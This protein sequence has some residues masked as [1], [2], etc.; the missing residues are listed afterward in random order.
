M[1]Y[2]VLWS[3]LYKNKKL[4][5]PPYASGITFCCIYIYHFLRSTIQIE[6]I[7]HCN[8]KKQNY[9]GQ[10]HA[11]MQSFACSGKVLTNCITEQILAWIPHKSGFQIKYLLLLF[12][13]ATYYI[14]ILSCLIIWQRTI[15][16]DQCLSDTSN[17]SK[18]MKE[19]PGVGFW[20]SDSQIMGCLL[21][22]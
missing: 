22:K 6:N 11:Q 2:S 19:L 8:D 17:Y 3:R 7:N 16:D 15:R 10:R 18:N 5:R 9:S 1:R 21:M 20:G 4:K 13:T 14:F 12:D